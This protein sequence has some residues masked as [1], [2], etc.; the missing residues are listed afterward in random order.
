MIVPLY[1]GKRE[2]I[3]CKNYRGISLLSMVGNIYADILVDIVCSVT[4]GLID[5][6]QGGFRTGRG[7]VDSDK[8][9]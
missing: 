8:F 5:D 9:R 6:E 7:Y 4:G 2:M 3:K 1:K